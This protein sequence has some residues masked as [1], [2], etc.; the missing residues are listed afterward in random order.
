LTNQA[1]CEK[2]GYVKAGETPLE[3]AAQ[4]LIADQ[5]NV[6]HTIGGDDTNTQ[7][8]VLSQY[9]FEKHGGKVVVVGMPKTID[10][11]GTYLPVSSVV[12][13]IPVSSVVAVVVNE[14]TKQHVEWHFWTNRWIFSKHVSHS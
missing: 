8:A 14:R 1:D 12:V 5:V 4:R 13:V 7:A 10:N 3:V 11:D 9:I 2:R 6:V